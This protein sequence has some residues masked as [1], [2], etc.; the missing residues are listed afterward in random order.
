MATLYSEPVHPSAQRIIYLQLSER[1]DRLRPDLFRSSNKDFITLR[2]TSYYALAL[3]VLCYFVQIH[4]CLHQT[5]IRNQF[6]IADCYSTAYVKTLHM[7]A[8]VVR[9][10]RTIFASTDGGKV[11]WEKR[12]K[13]SFEKCLCYHQETLHRFQK[14]AKL[15]YNAS[16]PNRPNQ[17]CP[18]RSFVTDI[19]SQAPLRDQTQIVIRH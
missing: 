2:T 3:C 18:V 19:H 5:S 17:P 11:T 9:G 10:R 1:E 15:S 7:A 6:E 8:E 16:R 14:S 4:I 12:K 13:V